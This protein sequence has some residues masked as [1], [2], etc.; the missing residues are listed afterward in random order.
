MERQKKNILLLCP[1]ELKASALGLYGQELPTSPFLDRL[2]GSAAVFEQCHTVHPKCSPSRAALVTAQYPHVN[3][4]RTLELLVRP[5]EIN[6]LRSLREFGYESALVGK[7]HTADAEAFPLTFDRHFHEG[8][9]QSMEN[10]G[11]P[12]PGGSYWVGRDEAPLEEFR[13]HVLTDRALEW[14]ASRE[15]GAKPFFLWLN[16]NAPHPPYSV[17]A[18]YY[19]TL[20]RARIPL[21]PRDDAYSKAPYQRALQEAYGLDAMTD[22]DWREVVATYLEMARFVDAEAE[23]V[24][25]FLEARGLLKDTIIVFWSDH[26]DFAGEHQLT[27]KWDTSFYDCITRVPLLIFDPSRREGRRIPALVESI[28]ILPTLLEMVGAPIPKGIQGKSLVPLMDGSVET[29]REEVFCQGGQEPEMFDRV[30]PPNVRPR[31]CR[32]YQMK[33]E[34]LSRCPEINIRA[35]MIRDTRWKYIYHLSGFEELYDLEA[36]PREIANLALRQEHADTLGRYRMRMLRKL[37][38]AETVEPYQDFLE[39]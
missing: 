3:G 33:Q 4:H 23:R 26:G 18:P 27:E 12:M 22:D 11:S 14:L 16:W 9:R 31:P 15:A 29:L 25:D 32:A 36:D 35:K 39:S 38:E 19:G 30:V 28:D 17:P 13:D 21:P 7:N 5:H 24:F 20:D 1:D 6:L 10:P 8:G 2:A 34:A 37:V